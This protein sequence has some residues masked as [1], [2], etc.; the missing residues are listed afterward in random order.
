MCLQH[1]IGAV[2]KCQKKRYTMTATSR[3]LRSIDHRADLNEPPAD[4][5]PYII[6]FFAGR[7]RLFAE[8]DQATKQF[9]IEQ[10]VRTA[11]ARSKRRDELF[12]P[13]ED[14]LYSLISAAALVSVILAIL[15]MAEFRTPGTRLPE[16]QPISHTESFYNDAKS[17]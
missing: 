14:W 3:P 13:L 2:L 11:A 10:R 12:D 9:E 1:P 15:C 7:D 16:E 5:S 17:R 6:D 4:S 8:T